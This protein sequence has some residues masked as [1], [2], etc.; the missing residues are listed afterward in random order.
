MAGAL[1][2]EGGDADARQH[3]R[4]ERERVAGREA[5]ERDAGAR[6]QH[7]GGHQPGQLEAVGGVAEERLD[8]GGADRGGEHERPA[9]AYE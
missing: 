3:D 2:V 5:G 4:G 7:A 1:G 8:Q 9:A 6:G